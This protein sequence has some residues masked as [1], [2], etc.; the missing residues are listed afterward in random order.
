MSMDVNAANAIEDL[1]RR[2]MVL[3]NVLYTLLDCIKCDNDEK[4]CEAYKLVTD[5]IGAVKIVKMKE[6]IV[7]S[8]LRG[9]EE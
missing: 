5:I 7:R 4:Y 1:N 2:V 9:I 6:R 3:E 8:T